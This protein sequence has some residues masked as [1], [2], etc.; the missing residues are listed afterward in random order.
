M[1]IAIPVADG[2]LCAHFG[3]CQ[4]FE[5]ISVDP[6]KKE[7][8]D[9]ETLI[10]PAHEPG[11]LP[12]WLR[13]KGATMIISGG[14]GQRAQNFFIQYGIEVIVGAA[15]DTPDAIVKAFI[16]GNLVTGANVCDH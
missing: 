4:H 16:A 11:V 9:A 13:Q 15:P 14:M 8:Q 6:V 2:K 5:L 3:H 10:P 7:I 12:G 1:K